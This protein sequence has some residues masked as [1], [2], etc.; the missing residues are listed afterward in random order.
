M[1]ILSSAPD[2]L[3]KLHNPE[4]L[5]FVRHGQTDWNAEGRMQGQ[6][7]IPL[8]ATGRLQAAGNG[9]RLKAFLEAQTIP[10]EGLDFVSSPL[11]RTRE[12][13]ELLRS[14]MGEAPSA[15][16]LDD[17]LK[18]ITFGDWEGFTLEEL[19]DREQDRVLQRRA[20]KWGFVPPGG[21]SYEMLVGRIGPWLQTVDRPTVVVSHGGVFRAVRGLLEGL[22]KSAVPRQDV[23]QDKVFVWRDSRF[24]VI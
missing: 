24:E 19:A 11:G 18:E 20:D 4:L 7:D 13:M 17:R 16:R 15:Y 10:S 2:L 12:T 22:E 21:E 3:P 9:E 1:T 5:I 8:N 14:A 6:R 23:P